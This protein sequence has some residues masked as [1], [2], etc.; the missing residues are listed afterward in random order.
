[1]VGILAK[2]FIRNNDYKDTRVREKY[3]ILCGILGIALNVILFAGKF[4]A[5]TVSGAISITA[6]AFNNL[7]DAG[8]SFITL[9]GFKLAGQK[10][11]PDNPFGHGRMEY[12]SGLFV[13][14]LILLM[15]YELIKSA[16]DKIIHPQL[17]EFREK[18][19]Q[20]IFLIL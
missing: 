2:I 19:S 10:P 1:M 9:I 6:D 12:L 5:G 18:S 15:A 13:S 3:G 17:P 20:N 8:S 14:V 4:I 11:D 7:S 16:I